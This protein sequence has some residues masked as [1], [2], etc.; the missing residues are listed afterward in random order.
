MRSQPMVDERGLSDTRPGNY[1]N[2]I[3]IRV[4]PCIVQESDI[5]LSPKN[6]AA[7]NRQCG[8]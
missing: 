6:I 4:C 1:R 2:D 3:Y 7:C 5:L 8:Y